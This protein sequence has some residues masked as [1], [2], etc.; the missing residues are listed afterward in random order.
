MFQRVTS[1][2]QA[3][4]PNQI[5]LI[6]TTTPDLVEDVFWQHQKSPQITNSVN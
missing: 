1:Q 5:Y 2:I 4:N 3:I 6:D